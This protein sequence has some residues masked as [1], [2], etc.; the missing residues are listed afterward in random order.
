MSDVQ[1]P[2]AIQVFRPPEDAM[3]RRRL[4]LLLAAISVPFSLSGQTTL[5]GDAQARIDPSSQLPERPD[6]AKLLRHG[7]KSAAG[8]VVAG[9]GNLAPSSSIAGLAL[10]AAA[11]PF[12]FAGS[13][14]DLGRAT[15]CLA[16]A[17]WYEAGDSNED[18][19]S[20][21]QVVLNRVA[22][23]SFPNSVCGVVFQ[24]SQLSTG[25]QFTFTCD[26]SIHRRRPSGPALARAR[27]AALAALE[28][29]TYE[30]VAQATH[31]HADYV[32]PWWAGSMLQLAKVGRHIFYRLPGRRG[33]LPSKLGGLGGEQDFVSLVARSNRPGDSA[34]GSAPD[35][36]SAESAEFVPDMIEASATV[37]PVRRVTT[38]AR[39]VQLDSSS[40]SGR[41]AL[42]ALSQCQ[43]KSECQVIGYG[44]AGALESNRALPAAQR[45]RPLFLFLRDAASGMEV[46]LWDCQRVSRPD[47]AQCLPASGPQLNRL[48]RERES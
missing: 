21:M 7:A 1:D 29:S 30:P 25:C 41:W 20:V 46:A 12:H 37:S 26:G 2:R 3:P 15:E 47:A 14:T 33:V 9:A 5:N 18:Q 8:T 32:Q 13:T 48:M 22:H 31:Y 17:A 34:D 45:Q 24:G 35:I 19:R 10:S 16:M 28:G 6:I 39:F 27:Q 11:N 23:P 36:E 38:N 43:G 4:W 42:T 44:D 40:A